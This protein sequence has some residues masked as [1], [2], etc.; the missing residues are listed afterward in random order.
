MMAKHKRSTAK[1]LDEVFVAARWA[2]ADGFRA[3][4][5]HW[6]VVDGMTLTDNPQHEGKQVLVE[7][8]ADNVQ[9]THW[10]YKWPKEGAS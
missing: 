10:S 5:S 4:G 8:R 3:Y 1:Q 7:Q 2:G 9:I 6:F